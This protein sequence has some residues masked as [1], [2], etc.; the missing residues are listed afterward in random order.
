MRAPGDT[1]DPSV[2][3]SNVNSDSS[4]E[5]VIAFGSVALVVIAIPGPAMN[6]ISSSPTATKLVCPSTVQVL[7]VLPSSTNTS[8][9]PRS[10]TEKPVV[11]SN[12]IAVTS[13]TASVLLIPLDPAL[14]LTVNVDPTFCSSDPSP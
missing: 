12:L 8:P 13:E 2:G 6:S 7:K 9:E 10:E 1:N 11:L 4:T 3:V 14:V 5:N